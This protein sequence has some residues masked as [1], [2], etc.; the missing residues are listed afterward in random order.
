MVVTLGYWD[1]RGL[2]HAI[3]LLLEYTETPYQERQYRLG[4]APDF[5]TKD[6]TNE[7][8]KLG[9]DFPNLPYLIDGPVKLT[10]SNA[11]L[12]YIA[13]KH[14]LCGETEQEKQRVDVLENQLM[15]FRMGFIRLCYDP[16]FEKLKAGYLEQLPKK[17]QEFSRFL[18]SRTWFAGDKLTFVDFLAY[19]VLDQHRMFVP[20]SPEFQGNLGSFLQR[21]EALPKISSYMKT[22][23]FMKTP[24]FWCTAKWGNTKE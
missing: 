13:R 18:G 4:P 5:D 14:N 20:D 16:D 6:W 19:D 3:R 23:R 9:L 10:Q 1:V 21:F 17:L 15:D 22:P 24:V 12:R 7:K 8:E 2:T 11:I